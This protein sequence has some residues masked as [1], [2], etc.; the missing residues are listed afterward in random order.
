[1]YKRGHITGG[2]KGEGDKENFL[3]F[4]KPKISTSRGSLRDEVLWRG[5]GGGGDN[6]SYDGIRRVIILGVI[7]M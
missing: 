4:Y 2:W 5:E 3:V 1:M 6:F 7:T